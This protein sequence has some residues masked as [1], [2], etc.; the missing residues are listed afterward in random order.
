MRFDNK[1]SAAL[2]RG[3]CDEVRAGSRHEASWLQSEPQRLEAACRHKPT[4]A[5]VELVP[6]PV[7]FSLAFPFWERL[8]VPG[9]VRGRGRPRHT[10]GE[11]GRP[12]LHALKHRA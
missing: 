12:P 1:K 3:K 7:L 11:R 8:I 6:F 4:S 9:G 2:P 5:R 10:S